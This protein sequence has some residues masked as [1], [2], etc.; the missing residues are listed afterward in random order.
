MKKKLFAALLCVTCVLSLTACGKKKSTATKAELRLGEY[1][2]INVQESTYEITEEEL[3]EYIDSICENSTYT[4]AVE[5][6]VLEEGMKVKVDYV[7]T[8]DGKEY[9]G[10]TQTGAVITLKE[11]S[12]KV[13]GVI[14][15]LIGKNVGD[16]VEVD[17]KYADDYSDSTLKGKDVHFTVTIKSIQETVVPEFNDEFVKDKFAYLGYETVEEFKEYLIE[18]MRL[19]YVFTEV[20]DT[21]LENA[22]VVSYDSEELEELTNQYVEYQEYIIYQ[23]TG[24]DLDTYLAA[25]KK[26]RDAFV[27]EYRELAKETLKEEMVVQAIIDAE[28]ITI[29][30]EEYQNN[31]KLYAGN[32]GYDTVEEFSSAYSSSTKEDFEF[33]MKYEKAQ[34]I[35]VE[36][37]KVV[38]DYETTEAPTTAA[39]TEETTE[40]P[41]SAAE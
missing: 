29:T 14:E 9:T 19:T 39:G 37:A 16:K 12:F 27:A 2:G 21:I 28:G 40:A 31:L 36:S 4:E 7:S 24:Y 1:K 10:G 5:E 17:A 41:T 23:Y 18:D 22:V 30:E 34:K 3:Q 26:T 25:I 35:I 13:D 38:D 6:G 20:W 33:S 15:A 32:Y 8:I 11:G